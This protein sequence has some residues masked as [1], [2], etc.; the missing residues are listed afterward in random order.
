MNKEQ[1]KGCIEEAQG[2]AKEAL[3]KIRN[4]FVFYQRLVFSFLYLTVHQ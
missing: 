2:K 1:V 4:N 3:G